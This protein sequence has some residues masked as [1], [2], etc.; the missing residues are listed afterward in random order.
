MSAVVAL[1]TDL[2]IP[3][4]ILPRPTVDVDGNLAI[5]DGAEP[6]PAAATATF[7]YHFN[8]VGD[9]MLSTYTGSLRDFRLACPPALK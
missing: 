9:E 2:A 8:A 5:D 1:D 6:E 7:L 4:K 3:K